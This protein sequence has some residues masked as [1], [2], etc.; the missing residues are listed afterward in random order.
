MNRKGVTWTVAIGLALAAVIILLSFGVGGQIVQ[1]F[2]SRQSSDLCLRSLMIMDGSKGLSVRSRIPGMKGDV[3]P[4]IE[5]DCPIEKLLITLPGGSNEEVLIKR[6]L[7]EAMRRCF[8]KTGAGN[9]DPFGG[10]AWSFGHRSTAVHCILCSEIS[11]SK[12]LQSKYSSIEGLTDFLAQHKMDSSQQTYME[13]L[14]PKDPKQIVHP[15]NSQFFDTIS[16]S[17]SYHLISYF[18]KG[19]TI[20]IGLG[21]V[22]IG[23]DYSRDNLQLILNPVDELGAARC[24][25]EW[26]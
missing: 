2:G 22:G 25:Y 11:F 4:V 16:T 19:G 23:I 1:L 7:A 24:D 17:K 6:E 15:P 18:R 26:H 14:S 13:Y 8:S 20:G 12:E 9:L 3:P 10:E 21:G 5:P